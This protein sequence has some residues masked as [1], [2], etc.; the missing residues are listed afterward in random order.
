MRVVLELS[1]PS[2]EDRHATDLGAQMLGIAGD[3]QEG[4]GHGAKE[5]AIEQARIVQDE[6]AEVLGQ[7]KNRVLVRRVQNFALAIGEPGGLGHAMAFWAAAVATR[8]VSRALVATGVTTG[9]MATEGGGA[10]QLDGPECPA[11]HTVQR[12]AIALQEGLAILAYHIGDF[13]QGAA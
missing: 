12:M 11:L 8:V 3:I 6:R 13:D 7:G 4:L 9:F 1:A 5:E 10:A 2:M